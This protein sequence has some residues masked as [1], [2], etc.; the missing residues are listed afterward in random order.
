MTP[1]SIYISGVILM[2]V[3]FIKTLYMFVET[4]ETDK[5]NLIYFYWEQSF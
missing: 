4:I 1:W 3:K 2:F 5:Y